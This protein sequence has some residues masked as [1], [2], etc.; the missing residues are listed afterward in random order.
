LYALGLKL[1]TAEPKQ[2]DAPKA[3]I[4]LAQARWDAKQAKDWAKADELR[5][6][7]LAQGWIIKDSKEGF[8]LSQS[9]K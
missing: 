5:D 4:A 3:V 2:S 6:A 9:P 1:F 8:E 7:V